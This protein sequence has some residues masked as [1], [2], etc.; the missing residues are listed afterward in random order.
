[1]TREDDYPPNPNY[2]KFGVLLFAMISIL[3][4]YFLVP[5]LYPE[6]VP[7]DDPERDYDIIVRLI[8][9]VKLIMTNT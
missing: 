4:L 9:N 2:S 5:I 1:M 7:V 3:I 8:G 6:K